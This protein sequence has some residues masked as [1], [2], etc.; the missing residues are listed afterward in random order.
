MTTG[1]FILQTAVLGR[2]SVFA[3][4]VSVAL[5]SLSAQ[6]RSEPLELPL[7][8]IREVLADGD[9]NTVPDTID[10]LVRVRGVVTIPPGVLSERYFQAMIQDE[11]GGIALF[12][13]EL[14]LDLEHGDLVE[15]TGKVNQY[16]GAVQILGPDIDVI[17]SEAVPD[18]VELPLAEANEWQHYGERVHIIGV[19]GEVEIGAFATVPLR[20]DDEQ[21]VL[22][23]PEKV[24]RTF[25]F[26]Q[27]QEGA[28]VAATGVVSIYKQ[29]WPYDDGFQLI[30]LSRD[31]LRLLEEPP[32]AWRQYLE[33]AIAVA[34]GIA[35]LTALV[36]YLQYRRQ[37]ERQRELAAVNA[38]SSAISTPGIGIADLARRACETMTSHR[39]V[40]AIV[41]HLLD[42]NR[43][44]QPEC[45]SKLDPEI[46]RAL[47]Y[48]MVRRTW[49][50]AIGTELE[51]ISTKATEI[52][53]S[54]KKSDFH[55]QALLPLYGHSG[56]IGVISA[57][58]KSRAQLSSS[59]QRIL[60][61]AA[62][63]IG[64][65]VDNLEMFRRAEEDRQELQELAITDDLTGLYNRRFLNEY[66]R[67]Q[68][69]MARRRGGQLGFLVIDL[70]HFKEVNDAW[71][72][73][74]GD[75][76][77]IRIAEI[78]RSSTRS[79]DLPVRWGGEEFLVVLSDSSVEGATTFAERLRAEIAN[80]RL[81]DVAPETAINVSASIGVGLYPE[82]GDTVEQVIRACDEA[83]YR[84][85]R[86]GRN[87]V[88]AVEGLS[89]V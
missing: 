31:D 22:Y 61:S 54:L 67:I 66:V 35:L 52:R 18:A 86:E 46:A 21:L 2:W 27:F 38:I 85:K 83:L 42:D 26:D 77:L 39:V 4:L 62:R 13:Y 47:R 19:L 10:E 9:G 8:P 70:D 48:D 57:F 7:L 40:D 74:A 75:Q 84:A 15:V 65:G 64:L 41:I 82:H 28:E 33:E 34:A 12:D 58:S 49:E 68:A 36:F 11:T 16:R 17:G 89:G 60:R 78:I 45:W 29:S 55:L 43:E 44:M 79:S 25:P 24:S 59:Q 5:S 23:I 53:S 87:R 88:V 20:S 76:V 51:T 72:H 69:P 50:D 71:G 56:V 73:D 63:L 30:V 6:E 81:T 32:P 1:D 80:S 14:S 37:R 3:L